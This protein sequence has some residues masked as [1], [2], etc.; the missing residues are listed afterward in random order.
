MYFDILTEF[1][2]GYSSALISH[3]E[4]IQ[5]LKRR[6]EMGEMNDFLGRFSAIQAGS[7]VADLQRQLELERLL[8]ILQSQAQGSAIENRFAKAEK[9]ELPT[10]TIEE[11]HAE[12]DS[13][14]ERILAQANEILA[15][16]DI[17][18]DGS[19]F[20]L[21]RI[22]FKSAKGVSETLEQRQKKETA[23]KEARLV[24]KY[25]A[26]Y[27]FNKFITKEEIARIC[28]KYGLVI[29]EPE[30]FSGQ[31]PEA[32]R[33]EIL[34]FRVW[35]EDNRDK[36]WKSFLS[37]LGKKHKPNPKR[38]KIVATI[39]Q[40]EAGSGYKWRVDENTQELKLV[41]PDPVVLFDVDEGYIIVSK[42]GVEA[43]IEELK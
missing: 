39:D 17:D 8:N 32:N 37:V 42:W 35:A 2:S 38:I 30:H 14:S 12:I 20:A 25:F 34:G 13:A 26:F 15:E 41:D 29:G 40:F 36:L 7:A 6:K 16:A 33:A 19:L 23:R 28:Q 11:I 27:P 3:R 1:L 9:K 10:A 24:K 31:I 4:N 21:S 43:E 18:R 5:N 22:G